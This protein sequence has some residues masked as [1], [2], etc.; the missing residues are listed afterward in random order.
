MKMRPILGLALCACAL[1]ALAGPARALEPPLRKNWTLGIGF[2]MGSARIDQSDGGTFEASDGVSPRIVF[3]RK[4]SERWRAG[5]LWEAWLTERGDGETRIRRS[6][7][8]LTAAATFIPGNLNN[9]W[10]G[11]YVRGG[12]GIAIGRYST[13]DQDEHGEDINNVATDHS[14]FGAN[15]GAG[16]DFH[17][18]RGFS[19]G[20]LASY[21]YASYDGP[22]FDNGWYR[23][24]CL[25]FTWTY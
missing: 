4:V 9:A 7:Q 22:V 17:I 11:L 2:G 13:A 1:T 8:T 12:A 14:G 18:S 10:A 3:Q 5:L 6:M 20:T 16:Y 25:T 19:A 24:V 21:D 23:Q 15:I